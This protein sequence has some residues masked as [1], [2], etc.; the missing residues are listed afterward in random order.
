MIS[1]WQQTVDS[2]CII[3]QT[4]SIC[5]C[6]EL[7]V[8]TTIVN[9]QSWL[10]NLPTCYDTYHPIAKLAEVIDNALSKIHDMPSRRSIIPKGAYLT[11]QVMRL[12]T[13][14]SDI[15][16]GW[17]QLL[18]TWIDDYLQ[19]ACY[20]QDVF[21]PKSS[22]PAKSASPFNVSGS[23]PQSSSNLQPSSSTSPSTANVDPNTMIA[24]VGAGGVGIGIGRSSSSSSQHSQ[25]HL[26]P[27]S[28]LAI[29]T[30]SANYNSGNAL[31]ASAIT[32]RPAFTQNG[33]A[34]SATGPGVGG[35]AGPSGTMSMGNYL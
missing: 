16:F 12:L 35:I 14:K 25:T 17:F 18:K 23:S 28:N 6:D 32:P 13:L 7:L 33:V 1:S 9:F 27:A 11:S 22:I 3:K 34:T 5:D 10:F 20:R 4:A 24:G 31:D 15:S 29:D 21:R 8:R 2:D 26:H 30:V 19:I